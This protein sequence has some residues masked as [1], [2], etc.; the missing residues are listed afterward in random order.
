[1]GWLQNLAAKEELGLLQLAALNGVTCMARVQGSYQNYI[2]RYIYFM[3]KVAS[4][5][6]QVDFGGVLALSLIV[7]KSL[8]NNQMNVHA[9]SGRSAILEIWQV[10]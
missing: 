2:L 6:N 9:L 5:I 4:A 8:C 1:M 3:T 10:L 7:Y